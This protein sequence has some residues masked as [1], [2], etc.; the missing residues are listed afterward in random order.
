[1][2][3]N[4]PFND[5]AVFDPLFVKDKFR[6]QAAQKI[7]NYFFIKGLDTLRDGGTLA[8]ITSTGV[9]DAPSNQYIRE[10]L[11]RHSDLVSAI[12]LPCNT[13]ENTKVVI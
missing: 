6:K 5:T 10:Y 12:R 9:L 2:V 4:I 7:H 3:S 13:F 11:M 1:M 8:F